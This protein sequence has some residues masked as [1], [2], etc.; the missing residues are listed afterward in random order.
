MVSRNRELL[1]FFLFVLEFT[2]NQYTRQQKQNDEFCEEFI[3][4]VTTDG[5]IQ[6]LWRTASFIV[7]GV[8][9]TDNNEFA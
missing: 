2:T 4:S 3:S 1:K 8:H 7:D 5:K 6:C 9:I